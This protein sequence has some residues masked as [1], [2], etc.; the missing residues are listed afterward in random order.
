M[1]GIHSKSFFWPL[2]QQIS[3]LGAQGMVLVPAHLATR[4]EGCARA[5]TRKGGGQQPMV[6][7]PFSPLWGDR[8]RC[9]R[10]V[11]LLLSSRPPY[12]KLLSSLG[13][14][15]G[16][17][18]GGR[19]VIVLLGRQWF[20]FAP[21]RQ[22]SPTRRPLLHGAGLPCLGLAAPRH[23]NESLETLGGFVPGNAVA[24]QAWWTFAAAFGGERQ[25]PFAH[26]ELAVAATVPLT[27]SMARKAGE[28]SPARLHWRW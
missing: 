24:A 9:G 12:R 16:A 13:L 4:P 23:N 19:S 27:H 20:E 28:L 10:C 18:A 1:G 5:R 3:L 22:S 7:L 8:R 26:P 2:P 6:L 14:G 21:P 17:A 25:S 11:W 15:L